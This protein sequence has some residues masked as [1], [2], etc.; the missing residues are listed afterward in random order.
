VARGERRDTFH[1]FVSASASPRFEKAMKDLLPWKEW[2][3]T[4]RKDSMSSM[5]GR[6]GGTDFKLEIQDR[7]HLRRR[8][9]GRWDE[10]EGEE[11]RTE[12]RGGV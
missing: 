6:E 10:G 5:K 12:R 1:V 9:G 8:V 7:R 4:E 2:G 3:I 11:G